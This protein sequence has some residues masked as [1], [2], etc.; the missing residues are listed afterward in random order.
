MDMLYGIT[1][2]VVLC[3]AGAAVLVFFIRLAQGLFSCR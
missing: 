3:F 1:Q 2:D